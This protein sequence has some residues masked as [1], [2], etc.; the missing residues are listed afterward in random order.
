MIKQIS[1]Y[2]GLEITFNT[3]EDCNLQ[4]AYCYEK[5]KKPGDL[6]LE[7]AQR[8]I[9]L[10]LDDPDPIGVIGTDKQWIIKQGLILDFIGGDALIR[11]KL[12]ESILRYFIFTS[13]LKGHRWARRW[14]ASISTNGT[15]FTDEAKAFLMEFQQ[16]ISLG[17]SV[18]GCPEIHNKNRSNSMDKILK[19]W[20]W[21][22]NYAGREFATTKAT[23]NRDSI[24]WLSKSIKFLHED[25]GLQQIS[26]NFIFEEMGETEEDLKILN[27]ELEDRRLCSST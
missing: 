19:D 17:I 25:L 23:L 4:C 9:D 14:R 12:I 13:T 6:P 2:Q 18:D 1:Q 3:T 24:P 11:P 10:I 26:M 8:F 22:L 15:L 20:D 27:K 5:T 16:N 7:Y 21:Y